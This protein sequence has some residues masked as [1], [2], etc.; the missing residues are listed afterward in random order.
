MNQPVYEKNMD[1]LRK[2]Y[3]AWANILAEKR[4]KKRKFDV[5]AEKSLFGETILK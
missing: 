4:R 5:I 2:K 3:P 1:A